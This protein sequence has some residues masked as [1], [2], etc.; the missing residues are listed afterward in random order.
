MKTLR[1]ISIPVILATVLVGISF[2]A[3]AEKNERPLRVLYFTKSSGFEHS[4]VKREGGQLS[5]SEKIL[6][7]LFKLHGIELV[8]SKDGGSIDKENLK[9]YDTV[10]FYTSGNLLEE[11]NDK[12]PPITKEGLAEFF[13]WIRDGG[14]FIGLHA[15][16]DSMRAEEPTEYTKTIGGAF[17]GHHSQEY[18]TLDVVDPEFPA[19]KGLPIQFRMIDEWYIHNQLNAA[20][21]M[22]VLIMLDT[23]SMEQ[24]EYRKLAPYPIAWCSQDGKGRVYYT[25]LGHREDVWEMPM[26]HGMILE[27]LDWTSGRADG[28]ATPN[29]EKYIK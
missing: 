7:D 8:C 25:G 16:T 27:A 4:V 13:Q 23:Q 9:N 29:F 12:N 15:A 26:F 18:A 5:H 2:P 20:K 17:V 22:H 6:T 19:M 1:G 24:E 21:N 3:V 11:G 28:D 14:G 10:M